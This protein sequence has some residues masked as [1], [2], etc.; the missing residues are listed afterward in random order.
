[1]RRSA[2]L[3]L[4]A[5]GSC[6]ASVWAQKSARDA[7]W[8]ASDLVSVS[9][10]P[11]AKVS[12]GSRPQSRRPAAGTATHAA[13][14]QP[15][16]DPALVAQNGYGDAPHLVRVSNDQIGIRY[17][18][19]LRNREGKYD[20]VSPTSVFH[21]GDYLH[22]SVMSNQPGYLYVIQEGSSGKWS[23]LF[24]AQGSAPNENK[25]EAGT[26]TEIPGG[27][28]AF[29]FNSTPGQEKLYILVSRQPIQDLDA[30]ISGL[31]QPNGASNPHSTKTVDLRPYEASNRVPEELQRFASRD[32]NLVEVSD[33][34]EAAKT[35]EKAVYVVSKGTASSSGTQVVAQC[36][37]HHE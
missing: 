19:M 35:G 10:N 20:D 13:A 1:M 6:C 3:A 31:K 37:L 4:F 2:V 14:A 16:V 12:T 25:V 24:P 21:S 30:T 8:S 36:T 27:K 22:L 23:A 7:F 17:S 32:L 9:G 29:Q 34:K 11:G 5:L 26:V 33:G 15:H 28:G 18:L